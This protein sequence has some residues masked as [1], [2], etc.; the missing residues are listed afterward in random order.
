MKKILLTGVLLLAALSVKAQERGFVCTGN[1]VNVRTGPGKNYPVVG[2][3]VNPKDKVQLM[4][5]TVVTDEGKRKNGFC[6]I[7]QGLEWG[8]DERG[9]WVSA[10]YLRPV[11]L[12]PTCGGSKNENIGEKDIYLIDCRKCKGKE[13]IK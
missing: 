2:T 3:D 11:I 9:G 10:Q 13:Y 4:K 8:G 5:G 7:G 6:L 12:C 1:H